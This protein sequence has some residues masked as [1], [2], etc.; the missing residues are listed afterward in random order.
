MFAACGYSP[1]A[2]DVTAPTDG[3]VDEPN[4]DSTVAVDSEID[5][6]PFAC[7]SGYTLRADHSCYRAVN[8]ARTWDAAEADCETAG[9]H[10]AVVDDLT[11]D[12]A[13]PDNVWI[14]YTELIT[15]GTFKWVTGVA[16]T[17]TGFAAGEPGSVGGA[18]C[19]EA[20]ADGWHDDNC[21]EA[22]NYVCEFDG[23][24]ADPSAF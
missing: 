3:N 22:K 14:G 13:V 7:P 8:T 15:P 11:E 24:A 21:P 9:A 12:G 4:S 23:R 1:R 5:A 18:S 6:P 16:A 17:Y 2:A 19:V 20:R 10:L